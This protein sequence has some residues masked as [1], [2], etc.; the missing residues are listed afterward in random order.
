MLG[1]IAGSETVAVNCDIIVA[2]TLTEAPN[3]LTTL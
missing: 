2:A 3:T 1:Y